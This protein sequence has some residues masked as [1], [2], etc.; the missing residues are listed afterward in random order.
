M[1]KVDR[2]LKQSWH[3]LWSYR[4]LWIFGLLLA[5]TAG[6]AGTNPNFNLNDGKS[7]PGQTPLVETPA[8]AQ[9]FSQWFQENVNPLIEHPENYVTTFIWIGMG[10]LLF[11]VVAGLLA[12]LVRYPVETAIIRMVDNFEQT[13]TR[14]GF[15]AGWR[16]GWSRR[17]FRIW[18]IDLL[19]GLPFFVLMLIM[20]TLGLV[21]Y[22][23]M[24]TGSQVTAIFGTLAAIGVFV[25]TLLVF[26][27]LL[28]FLLL[29]RSLFIRAAALDNLGV[30]ASLRSG[31][32]LFR[33][34]WK[35]A[36]LI[37]LVMIGVSLAFGVVAM[38]LFFVLIPAYL[39]LLIPAGLI[40][41]LPAL[42]A[43][44]IS[45]LFASGPLLW[46][47]TILAALPFFFVVVF[48]PLILVS[49]WYKIY[50][51]SVWTLTYREIKIVTAPHLP[52]VTGV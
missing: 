28:V 10:L 18:V 42:L 31:W 22:A 15:R 9:P 44:G 34:Q 51:S 45:S 12:A 26:L 47:I 20:M 4:T 37:Y 25:L 30:I 40:A 1:I 3:I 29:L 33:S 38:V 32:A 46:I 11:F 36:G 17:A 16:L 27:V 43:Y 21:I 8:W 5:L 49:G 23:S 6:G 52:E 50:E 48:S 24:T 7:T 2:I 41:A 19:T 39:V 13:G 14:P 35:N